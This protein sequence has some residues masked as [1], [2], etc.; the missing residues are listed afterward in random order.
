MRIFSIVILIL[1]SISAR[2]QTGC[3][4][5]Y[6]GEDTMPDCGKNCVDL[7]ASYFQT[8]ATNSYEVS[9]VPFYPQQ[10]QYAGTQIL[11][12]IDDTWSAPIDLPFNFC[13]FGN[14]YNKVLIGSNGLITFDLTDQGGT[15]EWDL[16]DAGQ[17]PNNNVQTN[18]IMGPYQDIDPT[19]QGSIY[20]KLVGEFPCR[21]LVV[22]FVGIPY[23]G[24]PNSVS[25]GWCDGP[26]YGTS[27]I[28]L[29]ETTNAIEIYIRNKEVCMGWND[30]L[31]IEG[32]M[33][34]TGTKAY[35][36]EGRNNEVWTAE[37]DAWRFT[38]NGSSNVS[39]E[40]YDGLDLIATG[41]S[42]NVCPEIPTSYIAKATY[43]AC[44]GANLIVKRD[45]VKVIPNASLEVISQNVNCFGDSTGTA[46]I[47]VSNGIP[48]YDYQ[49]YPISNNSDSI[50]GI[51][52]GTYSV[53][54]TDDIECP[55]SLPVI[56]SQPP[57]LE[58]ST[59]SSGVCKGEL[60]GLASVYVTGGTLPYS[61][62][63]NSDP[64][65]STS[66]AN[67]LYS[68][69][70]S[71]TITDANGCVDYGISI[72]GENPLPDVIFSAPAT[73]QG[74]QVIFT[75]A[76]TISIGTISAWNWDFGDLYSS[77]VE[78]PV[79][80]F[81]LPGNYEV[82][83]S[84]ISDSGCLNV[85]SENIIIDSL[86]VADFSSENVCLKMETNFNNI[87]TVSFPQIINWEWDF[88]DGVDSIFEKDPVHTY[89]AA[90]N[91]NTTL[92]VETN[93]G[94]SDTMIKQN[95]VF[96][97]PLSDYVLENGCLG[98]PSSFKDSTI[99]DQPS[100]IV[101]WQWSF[102]DGDTSSMQNPFHTYTLPGTYEIKLRTESSDGCTDSI[103]KSISLLSGADFDYNNVCFKEENIF[104]DR[105]LITTG[106]I[107]SWKWKF[108]DNDTS[109]LQNPAHRFSSPG[110]YNVSLEVQTVNGCKESIVKP[111]E[112]YPLPDAEI[113][114]DPNGI[115]QNLPINFFDLSS[116]SF[117]FK[118]TEWNWKFG[119][120]D[121]SIEQ[122][123]SHVFVNSGV[124]KVSLS[125]ISDKGCRDETDSNY[126]ITVYPLP[127][128]EF[129]YQPQDPSILY[130][131]V[132][133]ADQ[134]T[135]I[136][137]YW[138]WNFGDDSM[139]IEINPV[140]TYADTGWYSINLQVETDYGCLDTIVHPVYI[141]PEF[142]FYIANAF[143]PDGNGRNDSF[144]GYGMG[145]R[146]FDMKIFDRWG[147]KIFETNNINKSW[148]GRVDGKSNIVQQ[149][150]YVYRI[151]IID[152]F[153]KEH[154]FFGSVTLVK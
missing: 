4:S 94:C 153:G 97:F 111:V 1:T 67:G 107:L 12:D 46:K 36:I 143:T 21:T 44:T 114:S 50:G 14:V 63:W 140:H 78:N 30:G 48:P 102:G 75:N 28:V 144:R 91:F 77:T 128:A 95:T 133:F 3:P 8:G 119:D 139:S 90:G 9:Q 6:A 131:L 124:Y 11:I 116:I 137:K 88:G 34:A 70:F 132:N 108:G 123:T 129:S 32:I 53:I 151:I 22:S 125:V 69:T 26:L 149:D 81:G 150:V 134:T 105:S 45:T 115:C 112:I 18:C 109:G 29:Y 110:V 80:A 101:S 104:L 39:I 152:V 35:I 142:S 65:Q 146:D 84:A 2:A 58:I 13:F 135:G 49:W 93:A 126:Y 47:Y 100:I 118:I 138:K 20:W 25:T 54:V 64:P 96:P 60:D 5:V 61:F 57:E 121:T 79:H 98:N 76:S 41:D 71:V 92:I 16:K 72:I 68:G 31:A 43:Q 27:Q 66:T 62:F 136:V 82:T 120:G 127:V 103:V 17:L 33:N 40:W 19:K 24:D 83:L 42:V 148:D 147:L 154:E 37:Y 130:P 113:T 117:P 7:Y 86:P 51:A 87:Q 52:A 23:Y 106:N 141:R 59:S 10:F 145:I 85:F 74:T 99:I 89:I 73:C 38:P 15:C 56:I 55:V 122:N